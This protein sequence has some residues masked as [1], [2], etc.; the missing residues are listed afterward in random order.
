ML[1]TANSSFLQ[2]IHTGERPYACHLC[3]KAFTQSKSLTFHMRRRKQILITFHFLH[4]FYVNFF[5]FQT[6]ARSHLP[7]LNVEWI[8]VK[9]MV[10]NDTCE[11]N[12]QPNHQSQCRVKFAAN[13]Y[14]RNI[15]CEFIWRNTI[16]TKTRPMHHRMHKKAVKNRVT[17]EHFINAKFV[18]HISSKSQRCILIIQMYIKST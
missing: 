11:Q 3:P 4:I 7:A 8:F 12:I 16:F 9:K 6:R 5:S 10:S 18:K 13:C 2:F 1:A 14:R 17:K 15:H